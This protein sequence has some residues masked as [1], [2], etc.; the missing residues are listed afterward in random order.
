MRD[1][2]RDAVP[3]RKTVIDSDMIYKLHNEQ[4]SMLI[5]FS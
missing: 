2:F 1:D 4:Q 5:L 3:V